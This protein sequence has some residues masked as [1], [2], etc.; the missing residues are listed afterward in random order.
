SIIV[1][2]ILI[3]LASKTLLRPL[4]DLVK[5]LQKVRSGNFDTRIKIRSKDELA[6]IGESFNEMTEKVERLIT[7]VY[8]TQ[9]SEKKAELK[10]LQAQLNP[11]FLHNILNE[12]YWKLYL[13][14][15][16]DTASLLAAVSEMLKY[17]LMPL[18]SKTTLRDELQQVRNYITIQTQLFET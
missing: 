6:Y 18:D 11:H 4:E 10:A 13:H 7:E 8:I 9:L 17:S 1:M 12:I 14:N 2:S 3:V 16:K 5:G 15:D